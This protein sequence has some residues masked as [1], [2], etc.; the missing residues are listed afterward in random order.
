MLKDF[1]ISP[2][3]HRLNKER[4]I[5]FT[6][7][8]EKRGIYQ[9]LIIVIILDI[10]CTKDITANKREPQNKIIVPPC[11][12]LGNIIKE[13]RINAIIKEIIKFIQV[14]FLEK[15]LKSIFLNIIIIF[16]IK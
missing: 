10:K 4:L 5:S 2:T 6:I 7:G 3:C 12:P 11:A 16:V 13:I 1:N 15:I 14:M 8:I 9:F